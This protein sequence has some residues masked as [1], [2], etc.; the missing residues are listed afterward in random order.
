MLLD[1]PLY[2]ALCAIPH[3]ALVCLLMT[4]SSMRAPKRM[5]PEYLLR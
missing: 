1:Y 2:L 3:L 5:P 4:M